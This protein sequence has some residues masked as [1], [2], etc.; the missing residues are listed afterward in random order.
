MMRLLQDADADSRI[1]PGAFRTEIL[2]NARA[3][4]ALRPQCP[5]T[6]GLGRLFRMFAAFFKQARDPIEVAE[7]MTLLNMKK[8][9]NLEPT[10]NNITSSE[11]GSH[12]QS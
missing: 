4:S 9:Q 6:D 12:H 10:A 8:Q 11:R 2:R 5:Y 3:H 1:E 7:Q